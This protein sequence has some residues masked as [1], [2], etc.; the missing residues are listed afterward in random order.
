M[1]AAAP[2]F[3]ATQAKIRTAVVGTGH[4][5]ALSKIRALRRMPEYD[6]AGVCRIDASE[7]IKDADLAG[8]NWL[9]FDQILNDT[10]IEMVAVESADIAGN[11]VIDIKKA[12]VFPLVHGVRSLALAGGIAETGTAARI[13]GG[14]VMKD[15]TNTAKGTSA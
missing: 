1:A 12:G 10:S 14:L 2:A 3:A 7:P 9:S 5:H 4:G 15:G 8:I 11:L 6:F 13:A